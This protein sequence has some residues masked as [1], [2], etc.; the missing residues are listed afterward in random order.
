MRLEGG[1][2]KMGGKA[3]E[4]DVSGAKES[5]YDDEED[6]DKEEV[7]DYQI[8]LRGQ[9]IGD[10]EL[11]VGLHIVE[12]T[13][14]SKGSFSGVGA[15]KSRLEWVMVLLTL[16]SNTEQKPSRTL[17]LCLPSNITSSYFF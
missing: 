16:M 12:V 3:E 4:W 1:T 14:L 2:P 17:F 15:S 5:K 10:G 6:E 13:G 8:P 9:V 7:V 11:A